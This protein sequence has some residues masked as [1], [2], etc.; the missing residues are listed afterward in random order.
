MHSLLAISLRSTIGYLAALS[1]LLKLLQNPAFVILGISMVFLATMFITGAICLPGWIQT[2]GHVSLLALAPWQPSTSLEK[3]TIPLEQQQGLQRASVFPLPMMQTAIA[4]GAI[5][6]VH[7]CK[8]LA[9][10]RSWD[11]SSSNGQLTV[12]LS[13]KRGVPKATA[14]PHHASNKLAKKWMNPKRI[15]L[16]GLRRNKRLVSPGEAIRPRELRHRTKLA[17]ERRKPS[18]P[19]GGRAD[20]PRGRLRELRN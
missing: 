20:L 9:V 11:F 15:R 7:G 14:A 3:T 5:H 1:L 12:V 13:L 4:H 10:A 8:V 2:L 19:R 17:S 18:R 6:S 16:G